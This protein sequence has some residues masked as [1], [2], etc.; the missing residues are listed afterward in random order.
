MRQGDRLSP[1]LFL[2]VFNKVL[3]ALPDELGIKF[4]DMLINHLAFADDLV[5]LAKNISELQQLMNIF[6]TA[7][8]AVGWKINTDKSFTVLWVKDHKRKKIIYNSQDQIT[9]LNQPIKTI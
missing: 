9:V 4:K 5:L 7:L 8:S 3:E 2:I 6:S 1:S